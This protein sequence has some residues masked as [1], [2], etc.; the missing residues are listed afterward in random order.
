MDNKRYKELSCDLTLPLTDNEVSEGWRFCLCEWDGLLININD[1]E[2][3][4]QF[5][6]C[7]SP[8]DQTTPN[9]DDREQKP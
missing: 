1:T 9:S 8:S 5:C 3:E 7:Y 6:H 4:G 2:G